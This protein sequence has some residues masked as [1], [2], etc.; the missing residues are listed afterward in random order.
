MKAEQESGN[1]G[2]EEHGDKE[3]GIDI[4]RECV[5]IIVS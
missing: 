2:L 1:M 5:N 4:D 3:T